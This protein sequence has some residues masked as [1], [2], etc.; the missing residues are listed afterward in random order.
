MNL[1][2]TK[3][4]VDH[5][6]FLLLLVVVCVELH[7]TTVMRSI[8]PPVTFSALS[9]DLSPAVQLNFDFAK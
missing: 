6:D 5:A 9:S 2:L 8:L 4:E 1:E 3:C 7:G